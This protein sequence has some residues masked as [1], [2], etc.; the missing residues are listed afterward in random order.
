MA[1]MKSNKKFLLL[2]NL[3]KYWYFSTIFSAQTREFKRE[4]Q[5]IWE[6]KSF[7]PQPDFN[8][9]ETAMKQFHDWYSQFYLSNV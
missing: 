5:Q 3:L 7:L 8:A 1:V 4:S 2:H 9:K 6:R